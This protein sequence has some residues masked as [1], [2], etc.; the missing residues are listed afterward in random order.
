MDPIAPFQQGTEHV[1]APHWPRSWPRCLGAIIVPLLVPM[2][3]VVSWRISKRQL[4]LGP[5]L[6]LLLHIHLPFYIL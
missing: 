1:P 2:D 6:Q 5:A 4:R 3:V